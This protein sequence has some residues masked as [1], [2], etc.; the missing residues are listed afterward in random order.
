MKKCMYAY[1]WHGVSKHVICT[2]K[3]F[4][5]TLINIETCFQVQPVTRRDLP[6]SFYWFEEVYIIDSSK[7]VGEF[8]KVLNFNRL[9]L[10]TKRFVF[11]Y[12]KLSN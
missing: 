1:T 10:K 7:M 2:I 3:V 5:S 11:K 12:I 4:R 6:A 8:H 9:I